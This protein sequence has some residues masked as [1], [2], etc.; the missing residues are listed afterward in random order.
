MIPLPCEP[1]RKRDAAL[2]PALAPSPVT[3]VIPASQQRPI[4]E[5]HLFCCL[6]DG[7]R[8]GGVKKSGIPTVKILV[9]GPELAIRQSQ[10]ASSIRLSL[11]LTVA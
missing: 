10:F 5:S 11:R 9:K 1:A 8:P 7:L 6:Q 3:E 4:T 2:T